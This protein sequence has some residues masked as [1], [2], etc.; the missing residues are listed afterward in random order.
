MS[1]NEYILQEYTF[2]RYLIKI[3]CYIS[4]IM[5]TKKKMKKMKICSLEEKK[6][7]KKKR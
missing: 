5:I 1:D 3:L 2:I 7:R 6:E 4:L